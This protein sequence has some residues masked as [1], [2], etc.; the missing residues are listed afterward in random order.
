MKIN[1]LIILTVLLIIINVKTKALNFDLMPMNVHYFGIVSSGKNIL[2]YGSNGAYMMTTDKGNSWKQFSLHDY[3]EIR[4]MVNFNDTIYGVIDTG[5]IVKSTDNGQ[6]WKKLKFDLSNG[7]KFINLEISDNY[8][9]IRSLNCI[10]RFDKNFIFENYYSDTIINTYINKNFIPEGSPNFYTDN[11]MK[12]INGNLFLALNNKFKGFAILP[13]SLTELRF[14]KL[15]EKI[16]ITNPAIYSLV[17]LLTYKNQ[18]VFNIKGNLFYT[19]ANYNKWTYFYPDTNFMNT[20]DSFFG[21]KNSGMLPNTYFTI[22]NQICIGHLEENKSKIIQ[23]KMNLPNVGLYNY[24]I[25][26]LDKNAG[27]FK[28]FSEPFINDYYTVPY[29]L[30]PYSTTDGLDNVLL[31]YKPSI[32]LDSVI[33]LSGVI[34]SLFLSQDYGKSWELISYLTGS[35][36]AIINDST[37]VFMNDAAN[38]NEVNHTTN[39]GNTFLPVKIIDSSTYLRTFDNVDILFIDNNGKGF[40]TGKKSSISNNFAITK[41]GGKTFSFL[42]TNR[43]GG[44]IISNVCKVDDSYFY[45]GSNSSKKYYSNFNFIDTSLTNLKILKYD[46]LYYDSLKIIHHIIPESCRNFLMLTTTQDKYNSDIK[47]F[48]VRETQDSGMT[49]KPILSIDRYFIF[50]QFY[51]HNKDSVFFTTLS[52]ARLFMYD[53]KRNAIDTLLKTDKYYNAR[54]MYLGRKFYIVGEKT[55]LENTDRNDLT[56]WQPAKWQWGIPSFESVIF[57]GN[58]ALAKL[59]DDVHPLNY[60]RLMIKEQSL[61]IEQPQVEK[62]YYQSKFYAYP[63]YPVPARN[64]IKAKVSWDLS[65]DLKEAIK[66]VYNIYGELISGKDKISFNQTGIATAEIEW[67]CSNVPSGLYFIVV[68]YGEKQDCVPIVV[69]K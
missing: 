19:D 8:I 3:G 37:Y 62:K 47:R 25:K 29:F 51:E 54:I 42:S 53:R 69:E 44:D 66:G 58:V 12:Y 59:S 38:A 15:D 6:N 24:D 34:K 13:E 49:S 1:Y 64:Y 27:I 63:P 65:Y 11:Y 4:K 16:Y 5:Y 52:P 22:N 67:D 30:N 50:N 18:L 32:C 60:Y 26:T 23:S 7:D 46:S 20:N 14:I 57:K 28:N 17:N 31:R 68:D 45:A 40:F 2:V 39:Y 36:K 35:P 61:V 56:K 10:F 43:I 48:E 33:I 55:F 9:F 41:D 21:F